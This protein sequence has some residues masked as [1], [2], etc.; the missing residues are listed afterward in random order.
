[1]GRTVR[2]FLIACVVAGLLHAAAEA[3]FFSIEALE[4]G[5]RGTGKTVVRGTEIE[6]FE[7][8]YLGVLPEAGPVGDLILVRVSGDAIDRAGGIAA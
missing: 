4:P 1:M 8:E 2:T 3:R 5:L 6:T 7:V